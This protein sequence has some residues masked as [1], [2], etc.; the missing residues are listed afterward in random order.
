[1]ETKVR[2]LARG[3][4]RKPAP[5]SIVRS[6]P[7]AARRPSPVI[8]ASLATLSL[9]AA[10]MSVLACAGA[11]DTSSTTPGCS[12]PGQFIGPGQG[13]APPPGQPPQNIEPNAYPPPMPGGMPAPSPP[14]PPPQAAR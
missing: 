2:A 3:P 7:S 6:D 5:A 11:H 10:A 1:M 13:N 8:G 4:T 12:R 14:G 9:V